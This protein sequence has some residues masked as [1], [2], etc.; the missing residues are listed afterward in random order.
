MRIFWQYGYEGTSLPEITK[1][2]GITRPSLYAAFGD[3][4]RLFQLAA[5]RYG[6]G[7]ANY[8]RRAME[9]PTARR[10]VEKLLRGA[11]DALTDPKHPRGCLAVQGALACWDEA[12]PARRQM[13]ALR[14]AACDALR[15]RFERAKKEQDLPRHANAADLARYIAAV[16]HG[17]AVQAA[18]EA[19][20]AELRRV[21]ELALRA[22]PQ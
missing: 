13:C 7:P 19:T 20:R 22:W 8:V 5:E 1:A 10:A 17:M 14:A 3:K 15:K 21:G 12:D 6:A 18:S 2:M 4:Q 9:E 11:A 16:L